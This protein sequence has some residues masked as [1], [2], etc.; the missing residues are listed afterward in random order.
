M[1]Q[2]VF[3]DAAGTLIHPS[4]KVGDGYARV[5]A[6]FGLELDPNKVASV[7]REAWSSSPSPD[8]SEGPSKDDDRGW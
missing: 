3:L 1:I 5:A 8:Y 7:F 2:A 6:R 4:E